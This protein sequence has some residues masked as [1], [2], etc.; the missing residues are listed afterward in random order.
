MKDLGGKTSKATLG[1]IYADKHLT[2][3]LDLNST[4]K[5]TSWNVDLI[6]CGRSLIR[7]PFRLAHGRSS[8]NNFILKEQRKKNGGNFWKF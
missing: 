1:N 6:K 3:N 4:R 7:V 2:L 8:A 5:Q